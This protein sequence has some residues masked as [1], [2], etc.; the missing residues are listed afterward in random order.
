MLLDN[1]YKSPHCATII[2][3]NDIHKLLNIDE[4]VDAIVGNGFYAE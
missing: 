4:K 3:G 2:D 1:P